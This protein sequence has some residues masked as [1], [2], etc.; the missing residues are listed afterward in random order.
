MAITSTKSPKET[1]IPPIT[2]HPPASPES[3]ALQIRTRN[4]RKRY[5]DL[6][7][8]YFSNPS[9]E[10]AD[11]LLYDRLIRRFQTPSEREAEGRKK[12]FSG[13]LQADMERAEA[14]VAALANPDP[15]AVISYR[16]GPCGEIV[17]EERDEVPET[18]EEGWERW[19]FAMEMR[20]VGGRDD[21][22]EYEGVDGSE[23]WDDRGEED[24]VALED[25]LAGEEERFLRAD[26]GSPEGE[27]GVQD[28]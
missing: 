3:R 8:T 20:F 17:E 9:L 5:L 12:G 28:F 14:K 1:R 13:T 7:P 25:Y 27:T 26:G 11:P 2:S 23:E 16:R 19:R 6:T 22:F 15:D 18:K 10:L 21:D 4:R 24:R